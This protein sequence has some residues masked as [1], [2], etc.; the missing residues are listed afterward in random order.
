[1]CIYTVHVTLKFALCEY[2]KQIYIYLYLLRFN[3][4]NYKTHHWSY[5]HF[6]LSCP[7]SGS[8]CMA[9]CTWHVR[10]AQLNTKFI[11]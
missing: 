6:E 8:L 4:S 9:C 5:T 7:V 3:D 1:M 10:L 2:S 11:S